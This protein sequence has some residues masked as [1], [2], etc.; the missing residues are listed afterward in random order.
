MPKG[1]QPTKKTAPKK[2]PAPVKGV[3]G[4]M[5]GG[6]LR[7]GTAWLFSADAESE[8][9]QIYEDSRSY[10]GRYITC[11]YVLTENSSDVLDKLKE[12][13]SEQHDYGNLY[14]CYSAALMDKLK[15]VS[16][17]ERCK[18][19]REKEEKDAGAGEDEAE[20]KPAVKKGGKPAPAEK[21]PAKKPA[22]GKKAQVVEAEVEVEDAEED[23][24]EDVEEDAD[25]DDDAENVDDVEVEDDDDAEEQEDEPEPEPTP[26]PKK[27]KG[28]KATPAP[29]P[30]ATGKKATPPPAPVEKVPA[31]KPA[32]KAVAKK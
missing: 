31:K 19:I 10:L 7:V 13:I 28:A 1:D 12:E 2:A 9:T 11:K 25:E 14:T 4:F 24:D 16:G 29:A 21:A 22:T 30:K 6:V 20:T 23:A 8:V 5:Y 17:V 15:E 26:A 3:V 27:G 32:G 18:N